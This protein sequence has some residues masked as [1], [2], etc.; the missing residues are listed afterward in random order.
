LYGCS[1]GWEKDYIDRETAE[2][3]FTK[4]KSLGCHSLH[5]GGGEPLLNVDGLLSV[6]RLAANCGI[7][8]EYVETN[9]SWF[10]NRKQAAAI[11]AHLLNAGINTLLISISPFHNAHIPFF[12]VKGVIEACQDAGMGIFPWIQDFYPEI[13]RLDYHTVHPMQDYLDLFGDDYVKRLPTRYWIHFGGRALSTFKSVFPEQSLDDILNTAHN[14]PEL[15]D[16]SHFHID[17]FGNYIPG[18]CSGLAIRRDDL[19]QPLAESAYPYISLLY[20]EGIGAFVEMT[21]QKY[22]FQPEKSYFSK[23]DLCLSIRKYL[24]LEKE[25]VS[26][27]LQPIAFYGEI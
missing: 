17:L 3:N 26:P 12:K 4:V 10:K 2:K 25:I 7:Y 11:L 21:Q 24:V 14:C 8:I 6:A 13:N 27:E 5:I 19:G 23:C 20:G 1:P 18:L 9:S 16:T 15:K 22:N